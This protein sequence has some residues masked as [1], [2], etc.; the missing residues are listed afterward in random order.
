MFGSW[1]AIGLPMGL[2][3]KSSMG[4]I[5]LEIG[6]GAAALAQFCAFKVLLSSTDW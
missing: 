3:L 2:L 6:V 4:L 1:I 5:G